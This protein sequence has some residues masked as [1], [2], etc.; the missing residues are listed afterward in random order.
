MS[1]MF[2]NGHEGYRP[3]S[4]CSHI[5]KK[6]L[7]LTMFT[8]TI[9]ATSLLTNPCKLMITFTDVEL[10]QWDSNPMQMFLMCVQQHVVRI[11]ARA[12]W[13]VL[14]NVHR[15]WSYI[16]LLTATFFCHNQYC[17]QGETLPV[18]R[19]DCLWSTAFGFILYFLTMYGFSHSLF[20]NHVHNF[21]KVCKWL[22]LNI[23][24]SPSG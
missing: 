4:V 24:K 16:M 23:S 18:I 19:E 5:Q 21:R 13:Q 15:L 22:I 2:T 8:Y 17:M 1:E 9:H 7:C 11:A 20:P 12:Q 6:G 10:M 14:F 3:V